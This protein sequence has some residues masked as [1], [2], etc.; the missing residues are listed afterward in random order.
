MW[1][2]AACR[3]VHQGCAPEV[4]VVNLLGAWAHTV[5][6]ISML[7]SPLCCMGSGGVPQAWYDVLLGPYVDHWGQCRCPTPGLCS[8]EPP[9]LVQTGLSSTNRS[10]GEKKHCPDPLHG[11]V[12]AQCGLTGSAGWAWTPRC[13][14]LLVP[15]GRSSTENGDA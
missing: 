3:A 4:E 6:C 13:C 7:S 14:V 2:A 11:H 12:L 1:G 8:P 15:A 10:R 9:P 5:P